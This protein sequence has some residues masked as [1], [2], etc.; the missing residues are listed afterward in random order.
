M[1]HWSV[2]KQQMDVL[3]RMSNVI[4]LALDSIVTPILLRNLT[5]MT[6]KDMDNKNFEWWQDPQKQCSV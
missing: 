2:H 3:T 4:Q 5:T 6:I 1:L